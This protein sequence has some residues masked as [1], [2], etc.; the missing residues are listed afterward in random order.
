MKKLTCMDLF[1]GAGGLSR[2]FMDAGFD[3]VLG[4]DFDDAALQTFSANHGD[5]VAM[6]LDLFNLDNVNQIVDFFKARKL[7][8]DVLVGGPPCQ[9]FSLAGKRDENDERNVLYIESFV[10][11][12]LRCCCPFSRS[13]LHSR[14]FFAFLPTFPHRLRVSS[15][16]E[17]PPNRVAFLFGWGTNPS[18]RCYATRSVVELGSHLP[19]EDRQA[20]LSGGE[21]EN[22][23]AKRSYPVT[24]TIWL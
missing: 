8:L 6:K 12:Y 17:K 7:K 1:S 3:V 23:G 21:C 20:C 24:S 10:N 5:A 11:T 15:Q 2:G 22:H 13:C 9:G 18:K 19:L 4:V 16:T 14:T